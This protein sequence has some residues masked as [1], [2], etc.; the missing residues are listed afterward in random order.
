MSRQL[1]RLRPLSWGHSRLCAA[2]LG[3]GARK[4]H[5]RSK[6]E[7]RGFAGSLEESE[8][9]AILPSLRS[10]KP[11]PVLE[12]HVVNSRDQGFI[13]LLALPVAGKVTQVSARGKDHI[14]PGNGSNLF[15]ILDADGRLN[16]DYH[17][18]V[19]IG[20]LAV[21]DPIKRAVLAV[22]LAAPAF[23]WIFGPLH[24]RLSLLHCVDC[25]N[26]DSQST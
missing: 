20:G 2:N 8:S 6:L 16:Q 10:P 22:A 5:L 13:L 4:V 1:V 25:G 15:G 12:R 11:D 9:R 26:D 18:H 21:V 17:H 23:G 7:E 14:D 19:L 24:C 3:W